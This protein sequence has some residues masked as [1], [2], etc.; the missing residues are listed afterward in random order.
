MDHFDAM[1]TSK[2]RVISSPLSIKIYI[3]IDF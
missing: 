2:D 1:S 3:S